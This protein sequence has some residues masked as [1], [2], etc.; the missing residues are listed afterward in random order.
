MLKPKYL[1]EEPKEP[2]W[3]EAISIALVF[4]GLMGY[5]FWTALDAV[6]RD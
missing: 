5:I 1:N 3:K 6:T 4:T 2:T